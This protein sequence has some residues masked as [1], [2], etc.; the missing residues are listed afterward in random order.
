MT[1]RAAH[2]ISS[3]GKLSYGVGCIGYSLPH[4]IIAASFLLYATSILKLPALWAGVIIAVSAVWDA[5][6]DP[7]M[8]YLSDNTS[9]R[10]FGRRHLYL[11]VGGTS[12]SLLTWVFWS[13]DANFGLTVKVVLLFALVLFVKTALTVYVVPYNA[14]GGELSTDYDERSSIQSYRGIFYLAGMIVALVGSNMFFFRSTAE[15]P[16]G[17]LN[18]AAYPAMGLCF[19]LIGLAAVL[20]TFFATLKYVPQLP[21]PPPSARQGSPIR[22]LLPDLGGAFANRD[23][24]A[25]ALM[26]FI[27]EVGFQITIAI[28]FHVNTYTYKLPGPIIGLHGLVILGC[29]VLSQPFWLWVT[30]RWDKKTALI[31]GMISAFFGFFG[32]PIAHVALRLFPIDAPSLPYT[33]GVFFAFGGLGNGAFMSV[34]YSMVA[35][36]VDADQVSSGQRKEGLYF[37]IY[38]FAYK[39]GTSI[40]LV[41]SGIVLHIVGFD[42]DLAMQSDATRFNLAVTPALLLLVFSPFALWSLTRYR[43]DRTRYAEIR[44]RLDRDA[45]QEIEGRPYS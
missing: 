18:P 30:R 27:V 44:A 34:P 23:F 40:S 5:V 26:I 7:L 1:R 2:G 19:C 33:L 17:Q 4:Q 14:L 39:L 32:A 42:P 13:I 31:L 45:D 37:G 16:K 15:Y 35:D 6:S 41:T 10:R 38:T 29:S 3:F 9:N 12:V 36:T 25:L 20:I 28:G 8:G 43:L 24:R 22:S 11:L 21:Q